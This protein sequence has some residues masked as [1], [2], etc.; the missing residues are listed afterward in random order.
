LLQPSD[1]IIRV[2]ARDRRTGRNAILGIDLRTGRISEHWSAHG[3]ISDLQPAGNGYLAIYEDY[4]TPPNLFEIAADL[5]TQRR[6][7]DIAREVR[8]AA[9]GSV[10]FFETV[11]PQHDGTLSTVQTAI[12]LPEGARRGDRLP[13]IVWLY[14]GIDLT[15]RAS[16]FGAPAIGDPAWLLTSRGYAV[17][18]T[19]VTIGPG[20][21]RGHVIDEIMDS[22]M[23]QVHRAADLGYVDINRLAIRGS[24]F[25]GFATAAVIART[26]LF[27]AAI[28][29]SAAYDLGGN[30]GEM[31]YVGGVARD[32]RI[33]LESGQPR[34]GQ[35][36]WDDPLRYIA[37][38]PYYLADRIRTPVLIIQGTADTVGAFESGKLFAALRRLD[39]PVELA[40]YQG[41]GHSTAHFPLAQA[42]DQMAR[43]ITFLERH[44]GPGW[45]PA[46]RD[47]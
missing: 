39:R 5:R 47:E 24:S 9:I 44:L 18:L 8:Q 12:L 13:A 35:S 43:T 15:A 21:R 32:R 31:N 10:E 33:W 45:S 19:N 7:T 3:S 1:A 36:P 30:F 22:L 16:Q 37:N 25:G 42:V 41:G 17:I 14:P 23:P 27:R 4:R 26:N 40:L 29:S 46:E 28:P 34:L 2:R 20:E 11:V 38:S 6:V